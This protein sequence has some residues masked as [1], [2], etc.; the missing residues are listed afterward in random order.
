MEADIKVLQQKVGQLVAICQQLRSENVQLLQELA[1]S[2]D[3]ARQLK[4][5]MTQVSH[6]LEALIERLP[7]GVVSKESA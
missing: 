7:Q 1:Q 4:D 2:Q 6:R 5:N 3:D